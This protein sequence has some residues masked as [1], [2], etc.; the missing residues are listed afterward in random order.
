LIQLLHFGVAVGEASLYHHIYAYHQIQ[1]RLVSCG[2]EQVS[3]EA[4][5]M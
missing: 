2:Y 5:S 3:S 1:P 4:S